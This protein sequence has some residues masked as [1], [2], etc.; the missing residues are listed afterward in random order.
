M[1]GSNAVHI[2]LIED[3]QAEAELYREMLRSI[4]N[5]PF[6]HYHAP[7]LTDGISYLQEGTH[8]DGPI[9][10]IL[11]DLNL[12]DSAGFE[13]Y[14]R[15]SKFVSSTPVILM[16]N[17]CDE[18]RALEAV[19]NGA[20]DYLLKTSLDGFSLSRAIRYAIERK[21]IQEALRVSEERY[22]L[23]MRGANDGLWDWDLDRNIIYFSP[24]WKNMLG[25]GEDEIGD[26]IDEWLDR[27]HAEDRDNVTIALNAHIRGLS[28]HFEREYR[29]AR[30]DGA[31]IWALSRGLAIRR[32][33]GKAYRMAG[34]QTDIDKR[35]QAERQLLHDA[36]HHSLTGLPN[37]V[38]ILDRIGRLLD[39]TRR[40]PTYRFA[41]LLLDLDRFKV[42][43]DSLGYTIGDQV[44][45][46][47][48]KMLSTSLRSGDS[49]ARMGGDEFI[50][51]LESINKR[52]DAV[53]IAERILDGLNK[54]LKS[55]ETGVVVSASIG[56]VIGDLSYDQPEDLIRD[57]DIA[58]YEAKSL[59]K[60][61][62]VTFTPHMRNR[63]MVRMGLENDLRLVLGDENLLEEQFE[64]LFQPIVRSQDGKI[65]GFEALLRWHHPREGLIL[66]NE[67]IPIAE[68][69][70]LIHGL[71]RWVLR[72]ACR[73]LSEW[74]TR[75]KG[76][77][78]GTPICINVNMS[79]KQFLRTDLVDQI[80]K[81]VKDYA[82][83]PESLNLEITEGWLME[84]RRAFSD[85]LERIRNLGI[86]L[87]IDDFGRGYSSYSYLQFFP[88]SSLKIDSAF[89]HRLGVKG[90]NSEIVRSIVRM[91]SSLGMSVVA[92]G[93]E[94]EAQYEKLRKIGCPF[95]Q[96]YF[97][98]EPLSGNRAG[99]LL[100]RN[101]QPN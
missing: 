60:D 13:T 90:N 84:N 5:F 56:I 11:L 62:Y 64:L 6:C 58:M 69:T 34:S 20:Q 67:F 50:L 43:N 21:R 74:Q 9:D 48:A 42:I 14:E 94:T 91:A 80:E 17:Q 45:I 2:L 76:A 35:K 77:S 47:V 26:H 57:A 96:G 22:M 49:V 16:T 68:E 89:I 70:G 88:I 7:N 23:A 95:I 15:L 4:K 1:T 12:P 85:Q 3:N 46:D 82:V 54:P 98:S 31:Y 87:Q 51:L 72:S 100:V 41:V 73:Q 97:I 53:M 61:C 37:R 40:R 59:G 93:V 92:E 52:S 99:E 24:R 55:E 38:L 65:T 83:P 10:V 28:T 75:F 27:I 81:I 29:I 19:R 30:R 86:N 8:D 71:G 78:N 32:P 25:Y 18:E 79:G 39:Q 44:L 66:P 33:D 36:L 101:W 63:A